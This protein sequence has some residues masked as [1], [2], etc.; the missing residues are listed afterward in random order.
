MAR[1][2]QDQT[3]VHLFKSW[4]QMLEQLGAATPGTPKSSEPSD[5]FDLPVILQQRFKRLMQE[6]A[7][8]PA[9]P[10]AKRR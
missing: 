5:S 3:W 4:S 9:S 1:K 2:S 7:A 6:A 10:A 8:A